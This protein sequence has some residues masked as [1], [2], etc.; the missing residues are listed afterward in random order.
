MKPSI[1]LS[2]EED[3]DIINR[4]SQITQRRGK[5]VRA[6]RWI[7]LGIVIHDMLIA[8]GVKEY[9]IDHADP[10][11][12]IAALMGNPV[13]PQI[14]VATEVDRGEQ[15]APVSPSEPL[16]IEETTEYTPVEPAKITLTIE[17]ASDTV[18][19]SS[20]SSSWDALTK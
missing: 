14:A 9:E 5:S 4:L 2:Q 3:Q 10:A 8:S 19:D 12:L 15:A 17:K 7:R 18:T 16:Q 11:D 6:R 20:W 1:Y 13:M